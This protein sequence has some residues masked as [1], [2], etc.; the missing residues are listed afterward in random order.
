MQF[1]IFAWNLVW[2]IIR[3]EKLS[4][5]RTQAAIALFAASATLATTT[6]HSMQQ[7]MWPV[8]LLATANALV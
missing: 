3:S 6:S 7:S 5:V 4:R 8:E 2:S 1:A